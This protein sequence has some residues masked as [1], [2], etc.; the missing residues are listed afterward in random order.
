MGLLQQLNYYLSFVRQDSF[1]LAATVMIVGDH[2]NEA[3][4]KK[5]QWHLYMTMGHNEA[6]KKKSINIGHV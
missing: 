1:V 6:T 4:E 5:C 2:S 3:A